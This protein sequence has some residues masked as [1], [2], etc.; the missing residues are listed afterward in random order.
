MT[1]KQKNVLVI[2]STILIGTGCVGLIGTGCVG[3]I[4][5]SKTP[6][7]TK[8]SQ[9]KPVKKKIDPMKA[10]ETTTTILK[11]AA[12]TFKALSSSL[13][14]NILKKTTTVKHITNISE[15]KTLINA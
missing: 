15:K 7:L 12:D 8:K 2:S 5:A 10:T 9:N 11:I 14:C 6:P 3:L 4:I 1:V 13:E